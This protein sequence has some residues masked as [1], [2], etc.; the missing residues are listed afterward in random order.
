MIDKG[1]GDGVVMG[2]WEQQFY[3]SGGCGWWEWQVGVY[4]FR[5]QY[6]QMHKGDMFLLLLVC[7]LFSLVRKHIC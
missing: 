7:V 6:C 4:E 3:G 2:F 5:S 1:F